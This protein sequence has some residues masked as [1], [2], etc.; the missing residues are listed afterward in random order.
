M[1]TSLY[2]YHRVF[3]MY[4]KQNII[5]TVTPNPKLN[6]KRHNT[7]HTQMAINSPPPPKPIWLQD[8]GA[9]AASA[10]RGFHWIKV[11]RSLAAMAPLPS[12]GPW[13]AIRATLLPFSAASG[14]RNDCTRQSHASRHS[15]IDGLTNAL[16]ETRFDCSAAGTAILELMRMRSRK[17]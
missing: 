6:I 2:P 15:K 17:L 8:T 14:R 12:N 3:F 5:S 1:F 10:A 7:I 4:T 16:I 11:T 13:T 9:A